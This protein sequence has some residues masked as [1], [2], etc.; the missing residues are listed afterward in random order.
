MKL[1][2]SSRRGKAQVSVEFMFIFVFFMA[3]LT[4]IMVAVL[5]NTQGVSSSRLGLEAEN[6]L[7]L[8]KSRLD[9]AFLEGS[10]FSTNFTLPQELMDFNYSVSISSKFVVI[11]VNNQTYSKMLLT[12]STAGT[13]RKGENA[14]RNVNGQLVIS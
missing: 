7:S 11:E 5:Q 13:L 2:Y 9:T 14:V 6:A 8:V 4:V 10:G 1:P 3:V 12:N